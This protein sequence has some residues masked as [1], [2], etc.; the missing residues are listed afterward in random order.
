MN[1]NQLKQFSCAAKNKSMTAAA[2]ELFMSQQALSKT[3][4]LLQKEMGGELFIRG[5]RGLQ[6]TE[7]GSKLL[8]IADSLLPRY[9]SCMEMIA[10]LSE[11]TRNR[12]TVSCEHSY[13]QYVIPAALLGESGLVFHNAEGIDNCREEVLTGR[14]ELGLCARTEDTQGLEY[15]PLIS[16]PLMFLMNRRNPLAARGALTLS[17]LRDVPQ[18]LPGSRSV[19]IS[20][21]IDACI[22]EGFYP[23]FVLESRDHALLLRSLESTERIMLCPG[24]AFN[25]EANPSLVL[26]PLAHETLRTEVGFLVRKGGVSPR[27]QSLIERVQQALE[28]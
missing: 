2:R 25:P 4:Q 1:I 20:S 15:I 24:F 28:K 9:D 26:L 18:N 8:T 16:E 7:L 21:F 10:R 27:V 12:L 23:D 5:S 3:M 13:T 17:E 14:S 11:Q 6:L 22:E 19:T